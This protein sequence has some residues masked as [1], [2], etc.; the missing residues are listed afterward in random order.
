ML[1]TIVGLIIASAYAG[2]KPDTATGLL[3]LIAVSYMS[4]VGKTTSTT[5]TAQY[6]PSVHECLTGFSHATCT[7]LSCL[8]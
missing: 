5:T 1:C 2:I 8:A 6:P 3:G 4:T 7:W